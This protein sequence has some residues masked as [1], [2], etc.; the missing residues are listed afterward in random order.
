MIDGPPLISVPTLEEISS[1]GIAR[2]NRLLLALLLKPKN[3]CW[4]HMDKLFR[5]GLL[6]S[7]MSRNKNAMDLAMNSG[8]GFISSSADS[9][10]AGF[11]SVYGANSVVFSDEIL[12]RAVRRIM[13]QNLNSRSIA[14]QMGSTTLPEKDFSDDFIIPD[15]ILPISF[16]RPA[17]R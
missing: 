14:V 16:C 11:A 9:L 5:S 4:D 10:I 7:S 17:C 6:S 13:G 3:S 2:S 12:A 15:E 8:G 1:H